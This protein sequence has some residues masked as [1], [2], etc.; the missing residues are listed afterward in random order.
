MLYAPAEDA[1]TKETREK[2]TMRRMLALLLTVALLIGVLPV[3][4]A[5]NTVLHGYA[6]ARQYE[7]VTFGTYPTYADGME[8]PI[9]WRVL[10]ADGDPAYL[11]TEYI[12]EA[13]QLHYDYRAYESWETSDL[14]VYLNDTFKNRAFTPAEQAALVNRTEDGA[15]VTLINAE[16][17]KSSELGFTGNDARLCE[18]TEYAKSTG[19]YIYS[20]GHKYSPWW[21]RTRSTDNKDQQR[22]VMD[23]GHTGRI[24]VTAKDLG[25]RPAVNIDL[26]KVKI[27][28]GSGTVSD[29][30]VLESTASVAADLTTV[31]PT[32]VPVSAEEMAAPDATDEENGDVPPISDPQDGDDGTTVTDGSAD[33]PAFSDGDGGG[34]QE[35]A[36]AV[37]EGDAGSKTA[38]SAGSPLFPELTADG[39]LPENEKEFV[40]KDEEEG[41]WLYASQTLR[42]EIHRRSSEKPLLRWYEAEIFCKPESDMFRMYALNEEKYTKPNVEA[43]PSEIARQHQLVFATTGDFFLYR[44]GRRMEESG[45]RVGTIVRN[46]SLLYD[47]PR[48]ADSTIYPP[49]DLM[50]IYPD[51][52]MTFH[53][54]GTVSGEQLVQD[55][56][57]DVLAFGP[58]LVDEYQVPTARVSGYGTTEQPRSAFGYVAPGHYYSLMLE[59]RLKSKKISVG[60]TCLWVAEQMQRLGCRYAINLDGGQTSCMFFMGE[61]INTIGTY[62]GKSTN[63]ERKQNELLGI[64]T[65]EA[66]GQ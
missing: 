13:K 23:E 58:I 57:R 61:R 27:V 14:Y 42:V 25:M 30:Y 22:R 59:G 29:P 64:G 28:S 35:T 46:G 32:L 60:A 17:M 44:V 40:Y 20:K 55:G 11:L 5:E 50:A 18:S 49:L 66:I 41:V 48:N 31:A 12:L 10:S 2:K 9:L 7:Y 52:S 45:Y 26:S 38:A 53:E 33:A 6:A 51:G 62:D 19:L 36:D 1:R 4:Y 54:N 56:A 43:L 16:E 3:V 8:A 21:S 39:F 63:V 24:A 47:L 15:L 34:T 65:S 37:E